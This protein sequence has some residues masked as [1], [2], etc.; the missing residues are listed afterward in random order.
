MYKQIKDYKSTIYLKRK[1]ICQNNQ[2]WYKIQKG[3]IKELQL[4]WHLERQYSLME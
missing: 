2:K 4:S 3:L 1:K